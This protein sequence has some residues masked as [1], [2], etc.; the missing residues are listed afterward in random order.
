MVTYEQKWRIIFTSLTA[1]IMLAACG[2][3]D[4]DPEKETTGNAIEEPTAP[5]TDAGEDTSTENE[6]EIETRQRRKNKRG[7]Y[8]RRC[9]NS[10]R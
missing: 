1:S 4:V 7:C 6:A 2:T 10:K 9:G 3:S 8:E 5:E